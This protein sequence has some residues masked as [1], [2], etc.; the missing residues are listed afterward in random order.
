MLPT[1]CNGL[2]VPEAHKGVAISPTPK[3]PAMDKRQSFFMVLPLLGLY[4]L[5]LP[6]KRF[7]ERFLRGLAADRGLQKASV[8]GNDIRENLALV[9]SVRT[10]QGNQRLHE[11]TGE[12]TKRPSLRNG[13]RVAS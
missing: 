1:D 8:M 9:A 12:R 13:K 10:T 3:I 4:L 6:K 5:C 11:W 7:Q 2:T